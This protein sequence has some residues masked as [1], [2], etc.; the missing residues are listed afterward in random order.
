[1]SATTM[2]RPAV[3]SRT[4]AWVRFFTTCL[5]RIACYFGRR[6]AVKRLRELDGRALRDIGIARCHIEAAVNGLMA[7]AELG[8]DKIVAPST[9]FHAAIAPHASGGRRASAQEAT[10]W[11]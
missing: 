8:E 4:G 10:T 1:M 9:A 5:N 3:A 7:A 11:S 2:I 6:D